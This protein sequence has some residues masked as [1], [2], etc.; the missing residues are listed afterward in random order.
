[1]QFRVVLIRLRMKKIIVCK[2]TAVT[3]T[4]ATTIQQTCNSSV[5]NRNEVTVLEGCPPS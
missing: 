3:C 1:M 4:C 2:P 5:L